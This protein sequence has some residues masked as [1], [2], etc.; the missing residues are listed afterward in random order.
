MSFTRHLLQDRILTMM[1]Y[2]EKFAEVGGQWPEH[3][4]ATPP[5]SRVIKSCH[6]YNER[7]RLRMH[8]TADC[9]CPANRK[10]GILNFRCHWSQSEKVCYLA[11]PGS[12]NPENQSSTSFATKDSSFATGGGYYVVWRKMISIEKLNF[13]KLFWRRWKKEVDIRKILWSD[14]IVLLGTELRWSI[15]LGW[16]CFSL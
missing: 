3:F 13:V 4:S 15:F 1:I 9:H 8:R 12:G 11:F 16:K 5:E 14:E 10:K 7:V 6:Y 2:Y